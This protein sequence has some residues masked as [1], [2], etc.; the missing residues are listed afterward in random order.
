MSLSHKLTN[1]TVIVGI[2]HSITLFAVLYQVSEGSEANLFCLLSSHTADTIN[3]I[4][5]LL[6]I[7]YCFFKKKYFSFDLTFVEVSDFLL[8]FALCIS[9]DNHHTRVIY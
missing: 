7:I 5:K 1:I 4:R 3:T 2:T 9:S 6:K 8:L